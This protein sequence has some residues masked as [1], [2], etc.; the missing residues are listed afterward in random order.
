MAASVV[1]LAKRAL[2][3]LLLRFAATYSV[4]VAVR[5]SSSDAG[6]TT[7]YRKVVLKVRPGKGGDKNTTHRHHTKDLD[8]SFFS[9]LPS[10]SF[11]NLCFCCSEGSGTA[12]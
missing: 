3:S 11:T 1:L 4:T 2:V 6:V 8:S 7:A 10:V 12:V 9:I 5:R